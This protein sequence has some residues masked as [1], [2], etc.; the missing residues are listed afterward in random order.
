[1][2]LVGSLS[3]SLGT[4]AVTGSLEPGV[5]NLYSI[6]SSSKKWNN[7]VS[8]AF[9]GSLTKLA[10]GTTNYLVAGTSISITTGSNGQ[11]TISTAGVGT[12]DVSGPASATDNAVARFDQTTGKLIQNSA[13]TISDESANIVSIAGSATATTINLFNTTAT[14]VNL[15]GGA[16]TA[17]NIGNASGLTTIAGDLKI[18]GNDIQSSTGATA[19]TL[20]GGNV[21]I[22][23]DLTVQGTTVTVDATTLT[24]EDPVVGFGFTSGST[25]VVAGDRGFIGGMDTGGNVALFWDNTDSTFTSVRTS[26]GA[27]NDPVAITSYTPFRASSYQVGGTPGSTVAAGS[28]YLSSSD[29][30][31]VLV[32][33]TATTTFTKAGTPTVQIGDYAG[34][35]EGQIKGVTTANALAPLWL[36]GSV[37]SVGSPTVTFLVNDLQQGTIKPQTTGGGGIRFEAQSGA[38]GSLGMVISGSLTKIGAN[39]G[40]IQ[41]E[42]G[43]VPFL[44][45]SAGGG[46]V[47]LTAGTGI[48]TANVFNTVSTTVNL[49]QAATTINMGNV[50]GTN[51]VAGATKFTQ[52]LSGSLTKLTDGT[53]Y[54]VAGTNVTITTGSAGNITI[55]ATDPAPIAAGSDTQVQFNDGGTNFGAS[56]NFTFTKGTNTLAVPNASV[57]SITASNV[58]AAG[59]SVNL[60]NTTATTVNFAGAGT[61]ITIGA[62]GAAASTNVRS[63]LTASEGISVGGPGASTILASQATANLFNTTATTIN[64]GGAATT[65]KIASGSGTAVEIGGGTG[66][67][68]V[69]N[70][71]FL[72]TGNIVGAPGTGAN[73]MTLISSGNI[74]AKLDTDNNG[75]G[76]QFIVQDYLG[77]TKFWVGENGDAALSGSMVL[78]GSTTLGQTAGVGTVTFNNLVG[79]SILPSGDKVYDL[80]SPSNRWANMYTG[81]LHLRNDRGNWTIIEEE[82][83]LSITNNISGKRYKFVLEEI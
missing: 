31:N 40:V 28:A 19:I 36:S 57:T 38:G 41:F 44:T 3:G 59:A 9:S 30:L 83:Y 60:F 13:V 79:S 34:S 43:G 65:M 61:A 80:G 46:S 62:T 7:V 47:N 11:V 15:A 29:A 27:G 68:T 8:T 37:I 5:D 45:A 4:V 23:G 75:A 22:P 20:S 21:I 81:D 74:V 73:V 33:H 64:F 82:D 56:S 67:T 2:A 71:L 72:A 12:G 76:H 26:T 10:D 52:G 77:A 1:M 69:Y 50:A 66:R 17:T 39:T 25:A 16:S 24:I 63:Y 14:T 35:G 58:M 55:A 51:N 18:A 32:N 53:S 70:D 42:G 54:L 48:T 78:S 6:G 49:A